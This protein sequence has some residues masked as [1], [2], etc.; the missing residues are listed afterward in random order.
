MLNTVP[1]IDTSFRL[2]SL[3]SFFGGSVELTRSL[4]TQILKTLAKIYN[5]YFVLSFLLN[6]QCNPS[7]FMRTYC[8]TLVD[9]NPL[10]EN[11][12]KHRRITML[13]L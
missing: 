8:L 13:V 6:V 1:R 7:R 4:F 3:K 10:G 11:G 9:Q 2:E 5:I 12:E